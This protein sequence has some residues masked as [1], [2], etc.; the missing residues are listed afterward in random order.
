MKNC[1]Y[2]IILFLILSC[3][4]LFLV[5]KILPKFNKKN[6]DNVRIIFVGD[7]MLS[8]KSGNDN[9]NSYDSYELSNTPGNLIKKSYDPFINFSNIF[10][11]ADITFGN[12]ECCIT[13]T[14]KKIDKRY[15][16]YS[17]S[18]VIPLLKKYFTCLNI[19][20]NHSYDYDKIGFDEM[21]TILKK[22]N[23]N[24]IGGG[25]NIYEAR[26]PLIFYIKNIR[27]AILAYDNSV[28]FY[29]KINEAT[30]NKSGIA[31]CYE[32]YINIDIP[33]SKN[34]YKADYTIVYMHWGE[35]Y[36][37][38]AKDEEQLY[39]GHKLI[40]LGADIVIGSHPHV[41]QNIEIYKDKPI[42]YSLG[43][44]VFHGFSKKEEDD[45][46][47]DYDP[48]D[49]SRGW[50]LELFL[51]N[52]LEVNW[53]IHVANLNENGIPKYGG[54]LP[55]NFIGTDLFVNYNKLTM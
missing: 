36:K 6:N 52:K 20:N 11:K 42:F 10:K 54:K 39:F 45:N 30:K 46:I 16:F 38:I 35:E 48:I 4:F 34:F 44:F 19:A 29:K 15:N 14:N 8:E 24:Y 47:I 51:S 25:K 53:E 21:I 5:Y 26:K 12:L 23:I 13:T 22:N 31:W 40:D 9:K 49:S 43:N 2:K 37:K 41:T 18:Y 55:R 33:Y 1:T 3:V 32:D 17:R 27:I 7:I 28:K 50:V